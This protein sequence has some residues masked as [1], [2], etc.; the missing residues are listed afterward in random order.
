MDRRELDAVDRR[1]LLAGEFAVVIEGDVDGLAFDK[2]LLEAEPDG[3]ILLIARRRNLL[4]FV[5]HHAGDVECV[6]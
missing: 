1:I 2:G 6:V 3:E 5:V 4:A